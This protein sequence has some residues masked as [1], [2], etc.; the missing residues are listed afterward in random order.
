MFS[1]ANLERIRIH[2]G[3]S[4]SELHRRLVRRGLDR[5]R[6]LIDLWASGR[7]EPRATEVEVLAEVLQVPLQDLFEP[8]RASTVGSR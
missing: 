7:A 8:D 4:R 5:C 6:A 2:R 3:W 1:P